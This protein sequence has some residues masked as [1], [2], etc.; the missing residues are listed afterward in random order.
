MI[1]ISDTTPL[2]YLIEIEATY[3]LERLFGE[4]LIPEKVAEELQRPKTRKRSKTGYK[5]APSG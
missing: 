2:R 4:V 1:I 3:I 5:P